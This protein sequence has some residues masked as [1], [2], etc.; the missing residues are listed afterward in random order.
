MDLL[1]HLLTALPAIDRHSEG[2]FGDQHIAAH[3]FEGVTAGV[4]IPFVIPTDHPH[5]TLRFQADLR[6]TEHVPGAVKRHLALPQPV[7]FAVG[8]WVKRDVF[9]QPLAQNPF[10]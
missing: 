7:F 5:L 2:G 8:H 9:A 10:T 6:R 4:V 1:G 3:W